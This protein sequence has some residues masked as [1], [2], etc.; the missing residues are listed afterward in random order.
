MK[1]QPIPQRSTLVSQTIALLERGM[2]EGRWAAQLPSQSELCRHFAISRTTLRLALQ[3]LQR[4]GKIQVSQGCPA[5]ILRRSHAGVTAPT[6]SRVV[7]VLP[8]PLW[9][10]RP[11]TGNWAGELRTW[12]ER[13]GMEFELSEGGNHYRA[14]PTAHLEKLIQSHPNSSWVVFGSNQPMQ[15]WFVARG[16]PVIHV[17]AVFPGIEIPSIEYDHAEIAQ[18]AAAKLVAAG[19]EHTAVLLQRTGSAADATTCEAFAANRKP[20]AARPLVLEHDGSL[21]QIESRLRHFA[22]LSPRPTALFVTKSHAIP[23][24]LTILPRLG[25]EIP[26]DLSVICREDDPFLGYLVPAI[27]RYSSDSSAI[28][29][30][31]GVALRRLACGQALKITHDRIMPRFLAGQSVGPVAR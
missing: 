30:K 16:L 10:L 7:L 19:H 24:V 1:P 29:R 4:R 9:C 23:A 22:R 2:K 28:A 6:I 21:A 14:Q 13:A 31:L 8:E 26:R 25:M 5:I 11:A 15:A 12:V 3:A 20:G 18:H 17:G 27:A